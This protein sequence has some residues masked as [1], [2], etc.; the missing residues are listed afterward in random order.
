[1]FNDADGVDVLDVVLVFVTDSA[2]EMGSSSLKTIVDYGNMLPFDSN[3][4]LMDLS[5]FVLD[6]RE[7]DLFHR[8]VSVVL[9]WYFAIVFERIHS[10]NVLVE[11]SNNSSF[12]Y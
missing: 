10:Y 11:N 8:L 7:K 2:V 4:D 3:Q 5:I 6:F 9:E 1:M 12:D